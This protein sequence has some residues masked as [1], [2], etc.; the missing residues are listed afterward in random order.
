[1]VLILMNKGWYVGRSSV[2]KR[3]IEYVASKNQ[4]KTY[5]RTNSWLTVETHR[6]GVHYHSLDSSIDVRFFPATAPR[7]VLYYTSSTYSKIYLIIKSVHFK[8]TMS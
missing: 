7:S 2:N 4:I 8:A 1:M 3:E 6:E 5:D